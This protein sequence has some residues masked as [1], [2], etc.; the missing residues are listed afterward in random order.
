MITLSLSMARAG[1]YSTVIITLKTMFVHCA[2][3]RL[4]RPAIVGRSRPT[5]DNIGNNAM[6]NSNSMRN[7]SAAIAVYLCSAI[8]PLKAHSQ[9][10]RTLLIGDSI[11][12]QMSQDVVMQGTAVFAAGG[13]RVTEGAAYAV[14]S[15]ISWHAGWGGAPLIDSVIVLLGVNDWKRQAHILRF[16]LAYKQMIGSSPVPVTC[17]LPIPARD[18]LLRPRSLNLYRLAIKDVCTYVRDPREVIPQWT[19]EL[20]EDSVHLNPNGSAVL[21]DWLL[22]P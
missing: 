3:A 17:I 20:Y 9:V 11:T 5:P 13:A 12:V 1:K 22:N 10:V 15:A 4:L 16:K 6:M 19:S 21:A 18:E 2:N 8:V 7:L 14:P